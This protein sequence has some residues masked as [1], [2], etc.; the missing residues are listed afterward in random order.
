MRVSEWQKGLGR[1]GGFWWLV[2][3]W[4]WIWRCWGGLGDG[5]GWDFIEVGWNGNGIYLGFKDGI[6]FKTNK[7]LFFRIQS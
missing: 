6:Y 1:V 4:I 5:F 2:E 3:A 7:K